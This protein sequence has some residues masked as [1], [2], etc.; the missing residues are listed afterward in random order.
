MFKRSE[1]TVHEI[2]ELLQ[3]ANPP[4]LVDVREQSEWDLVHLPQSQLATQ[5]LVEEMLSQW[6]RDTHIVT[7]CHHGVRSINA[8]NYLQS[9]G[10]SNVR[11]MRGGLDAWAREI[12]PT[13]PRY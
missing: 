5:E 12:D 1:Y 8:A 4:K 9:Q 11:S 3:A 7:I 10:F 6:P 2:V 13:L